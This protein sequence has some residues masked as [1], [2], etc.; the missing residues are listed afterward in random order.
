MDYPF[1]K[2]LSEEQIQI[3]KTTC[4]GGTLETMNTVES[5]FASW[6]HANFLAQEVVR[7]ALWLES[8]DK[9]NSQLHS[10]QVD[11]LN[12]LKAKEQE[13]QTK[14]DEI[15]RLWNRI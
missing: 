7:L 1:L 5:G 15:L 2:H 12:R 13:I 3:L 6:G 9:A 14:N 11:L 4:E 8:R 10:E